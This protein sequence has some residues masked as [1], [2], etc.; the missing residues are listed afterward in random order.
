MSHRVRGPSGNT[1]ALIENMIQF[2]RAYRPSVVMS[3]L[4]RIPRSV[5]AAAVAKTGIPGRETASEVEEVLASG[6]VPPANPDPRSQVSPAAGI[7][8]RTPADVAAGTYPD[9]EDMLPYTGWKRRRTS[10]MDAGYSELDRVISSSLEQRFRDGGV[11]ETLF[12]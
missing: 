12:H 8:F 2:L 6:S 5:P 11:L 1:P 9:S 3:E 4:P 10:E 7:P